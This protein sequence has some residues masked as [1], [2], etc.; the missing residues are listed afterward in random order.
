LYDKWKA[1]GLM[2]PF[3]DYAQLGT[4]SQVSAMHDETGQG[5]FL[6]TNIHAFRQFTGSHYPPN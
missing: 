2:I 1:S 6:S 5:F 4:H 3:S